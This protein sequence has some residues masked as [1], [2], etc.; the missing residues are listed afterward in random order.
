MHKSLLGLALLTLTVSPVLAGDDDLLQNGDF[1]RKGGQAVDGWMTIWP[2]QIQDPAPRFERLEED[3]HGG[4]ACALIETSKPGG[5]TSLTQEVRGDSKADL[6]VLRGWVRVDE[7]DEGA[8]ASF[9]LL[10]MDGEGESL[11]M[12]KSRA[13]TSA[14]PWTQ[15]EL[16]AVVPEGATRWML[17]CGV[18]GKGRVAFDDVELFGEKAKG[19]LLP[20]KLVVHT[21]TYVVR[22]PQKCKAP[23]VSM[24]I[25]FPFE[26][27]SPLALRVVSDPPGQV[28]RLELLDE[29]EN[30]PLRV[31]LERQ[32]RGAEVKL[33]VS[34]LAMVADR[35]VSE[36]V[37]VALG[38]P[39]KA[40]K[41]VRRFLGAA[42]GI[43]LDAELV[44]EAAAGFDKTDLSTLMQDLVTFLQEKLEY[45]GGGNQGAQE[46]LER[47]NAVCTGY[48]NVAASL[49]LAADVPS[50]IL[51]ST[52]T[53]GRLQEHYIVEVWTKEL[54]WSRI[55]STMARFPWADS[56]NLVLRIVEPKAWRSSSDVPIYVET[57]GGAQ[58]GFDLGEDSCWQGA[59]TLAT[60]LVQAKGFARLEEA[61]RKRFEAQVKRPARGGWVSFLPKEK[62]R[63][64][65][66]LDERT[67]KLLVAAEEW[68]AGGD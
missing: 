67:E 54:G 40:P 3:P 14:G 52:Q 60:R 59:E 43:D 64:K 45:V 22:A 48:A 37:G 31:V 23:W 68:G 25:P 57:G 11:G 10:F 61:T 5:F 24:S 20:S 62:A 44:Q 30:R 35:P 9:L 18:A 19:D 4:E 66:K 36:G 15:L 13:L 2:R 65:L 6:A 28:A 34:T 38:K 50:R 46:C 8:S 39:R 55:E 16:E 33:A 29:G 56:N 58:G 1:E 49:L 21:G 47:G 32:E 41:N 42:P 7:L 63:K 27:Q 26:R 51:A 53:T 12:Q 17:R